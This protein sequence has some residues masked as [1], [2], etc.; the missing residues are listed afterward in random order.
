L[1]DKE[2]KLVK[3][4]RKLKIQKKREVEDQLSQISL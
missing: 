1:H 3:L 2:E 4:T